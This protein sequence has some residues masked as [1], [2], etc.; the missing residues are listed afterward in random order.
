MATVLSCEASSI[1]RI[2]VKGFVPEGNVDII[3]DAP[4]VLFGVVGKNEDQKF[5]GRLLAT[6]LIRVS[7]K[8]VYGAV[9]R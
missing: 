8:P 6:P 4:D 5:H 7:G 9:Q 2:S 3:E 1:R